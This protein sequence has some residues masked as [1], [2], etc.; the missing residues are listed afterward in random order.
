MDTAPDA[1]GRES[2]SWLYYQTA[3]NCG[4]SPEGLLVDPYEMFVA[5]VN[6][7]GFQDVLVGGSLVVEPLRRSIR[8]RAF[9]HNRRSPELLSRIDAGS[10]NSL[11][12][13]YA[14]LNDPA[15]H[16]PQVSAFPRFR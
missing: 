11:G 10:G 7:D 8:W 9:L 1:A 4:F 5:D 6:G 15:V 2:A 16:T 3:A 13:E 12:I 14:R